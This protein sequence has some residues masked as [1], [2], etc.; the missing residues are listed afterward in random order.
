MVEKLAS[1]LT[2]SNMNGSP[3]TSKMQSFSYMPKPTQNGSAKSQTWQQRCAVGEEESHSKTQ[4]GKKEKAPSLPFSSYYQ[5]IKKFGTNS[6]IPFA[7]KAPCGSEY[8][9]GWW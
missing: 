2:N 1:G 7:Q 4:K 3:V 6:M 9:I 5:Q 8:M